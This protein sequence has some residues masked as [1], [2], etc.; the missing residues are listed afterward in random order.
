MNKKTKVVLL[1]LGLAALIYFFVIKKQG[2]QILNVIAP[3]KVPSDIEPA[4]AQK[5]P[6]NGSP[7]T[8]AIWDEISGVMGNRVRIHV[9]GKASPDIN[10]CLDNSAMA[11]LGITNKECK[12]KI[13]DHQAF[14]DRYIGEVLGWLKGANISATGNNV[15]LFA[16][17]IGDHLAAGRGM[18]AEIVTVGQYLN[19]QT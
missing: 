7:K 15:W 14:Y 6:W 10:P 16:K 19:N 13:A 17:Q 2:G 18:D 1:I 4:L 9:E 11:K 5:S 3:Y 8:Q 12:E